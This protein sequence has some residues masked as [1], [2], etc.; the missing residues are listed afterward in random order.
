M[1][2]NIIIVTIIFITIILIPTIYGYKQLDHSD[3]KKVNKTLTD[4]EIFYRDIIKYPS[5]QENLKTKYYEVYQTIKVEDPNI[6]FIRTL[7]FVNHPEFLN[8]KNDSVKAPIINGLL[9]VNRTFT[10]SKNDIP[11]NLVTV[12]GINYVKRTGEKMQ[13]DKTAFIN[14]KE[15]L[16]EATK[17]D[18]SLL[19]YSGYRSYEKQMSL[20]ENSDFNVNDPYLAVPGHSEHQTGLALDVATTESG[21]TTNFKNTEAYNFLKSYAAKYGF[22]IRYPENKTMITGYNEEPWHL[23]YVGDAATFITENNLSLEEY[24]YYYCEITYEDSY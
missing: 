10:L 14:Y 9:L 20:F 8:S 2:K 21:L 7:N 1:K 6:R 12:D 23:R 15:L 17:K 22:I 19:L 3:S 5:Y 24:L 18:I 16:K 4:E 13:L 11:N